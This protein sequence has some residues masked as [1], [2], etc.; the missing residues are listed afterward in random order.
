MT[1]IVWLM[2]PMGALL[3]DACFADP[4]FPP[5]P[6]R[7]IGVFYRRLEPVIRK[8]GHE[9]PFGAAAVA[10]AGC[11]CALAAHF[12]CHYPVTGLFFALYLS[13]SGLALGSLLRE[14]DL[15][16]EKIENADIIQA[17]NAVSMLVSRDVANM[18]RPQL[19]RALAESLSENFNDGFIAPFFWLCCGGPGG[20]WAYK[21][22]STADS[23]WGYTTPKWC[24]L[25]WGGARLDDLL[26]WAPARLAALFLLAGSFFCQCP[27][28]FPGWSAIRRQARRMASPNSGWP[29]CMAAW[30]HGRRMGG[31]TPYFGRIVQKPL[32]GPDAA[33]GWTPQGVRQLLGHV[34][35]SGM[36]GG[37]A[38]WAAAALF[39]ILF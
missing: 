7:F 22:I 28:H 18:E 10:L 32:L 37:Y 8:R 19:C 34:W 26:A 39:S 16:A 4:P 21:A 13:F 33:C 17:R 31:A 9:R 11:G 1:D 35:I 14:V 5:H 15:A 36:L 23:M 27:G 12:L 38:I 3:L 2:L 24:S 30:L 20:L 25:G 6:V 29:M